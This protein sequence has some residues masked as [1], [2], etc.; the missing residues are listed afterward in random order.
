MDIIDQLWYGNINP[1]HN[2]TSH[3]IIELE[4]LIETHYEKLSE[5]GKKEIITELE[6]Y[7]DCYDEYC[8]LLTEQAFKSGFCLCAKLLSISYLYPTPTK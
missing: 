4:N 2:I 6:K 1:I 8:S 7:K 3:E 5:S